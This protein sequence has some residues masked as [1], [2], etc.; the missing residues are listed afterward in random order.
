[1]KIIIT[2][3]QLKL[4]KESVQKEDLFRYWDKQ[5]KSGIEPTMIN[6]FTKV[7][8][9][10]PHERD[11]GS[12]WIEYNGGLETV[13]NKVIDFLD[14]K[15]FDIN[16]YM[17]KINTGSYNF[18][19]SVNTDTM[20]IDHH[21]NIDVDLNVFDFSFEDPETGE[22]ITDI[23]TTD[24]PFEV[25]Y[26]VTDICNLIMDSELLTKFGFYFSVNKINFI[27]S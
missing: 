7:N 20:Q 22:I 10:N 27:K 16:D 6:N 18:K 13:V 9:I 14:N 23:Y 3:S 21:N 25:I 12:Y 2:E 1:M 8:N 19:F 11:L 5:K 17:D 26:E 15:V 4:L 24:Y